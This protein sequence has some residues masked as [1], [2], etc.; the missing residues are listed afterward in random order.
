MTER[1][2]G[3]ILLNPP[4]GAGARTINHLDHARKA[5]GC[6]RME[7][8]N[9]VNVQTLGIRD[10]STAASQFDVW[11]SSR[12][13]VRSLLIKSDEVLFGWGISPL[14]GPA[15]IHLRT[16]SAWVTQEA[17]NLHLRPW[18]LGGEVRHPSR[19][20][21][22]LAPK[23]GRS[24]NHSFAI[25]IARALKPLDLRLKASNAGSPTMSIQ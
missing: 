15:G 6:N 2:L 1:L 17:L 16:Q 10:L 12:I 21:Q 3:A 20:H 24:T 23:H 8:A 9:L 14:N 5:L 7:I 19:W 4:I 22:Y 11:E 13:A 18:A 25:R